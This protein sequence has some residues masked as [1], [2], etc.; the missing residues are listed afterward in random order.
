MAELT[1]MGVRIC[2]PSRKLLALE[3]GWRNVP[4]PELIV[5]VWPVTRGFFSP[6]N[7][8]GRGRRGRV[9]KELRIYITSLKRKSGQQSSHQRYTPVHHK[10]DS[11]TTQAGKDGRIPDPMGLPIY[12]STA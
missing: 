9:W 7:G 11:Q 3:G 6:S 2:K 4:I 1:V 8:E 5:G 10:S 12:R